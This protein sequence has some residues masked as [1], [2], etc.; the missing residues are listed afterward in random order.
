MANF[1][2]LLFNFQLS[3]FKHRVGQ[4]SSSVNLLAIT[5]HWYSLVWRGMHCACVFQGPDDISN[6]DPQFTEKQAEIGNTPQDSEF[7]P[8]AGLFDGELPCLCHCHLPMCPCARVNL[9]VGPAV[10]E[11]SSPLPEWCLFVF[12]NVVPVNMLAVSTI[13]RVCLLLH[14]VLTN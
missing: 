4:P 5:V 3:A 12:M 1:Q 7:K 9:V 10:K 2:H 14:T 13:S 8:D 11:S 6:V